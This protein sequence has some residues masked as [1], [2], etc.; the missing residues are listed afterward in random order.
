[1]KSDFKKIIQ[2]DEMLDDEIKL[3]KYIDD[4]ESSNDI[5]NYEDIE[6]RILNKI[7]NIKNENKQMKN[8][9]K[10]TKFDYLKVAGF[11]ILVLI[12]WNIGS[13]TGILSN[14]QVN[15]DTSKESENKQTKQSIDEIYQNINGVTNKI[16]EFFVTPTNL[17]RG[18]E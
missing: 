15:A 5:N 2:I 1:M 18:N 9:Q 12:L 10:M 11:T 6:D 16:S 14:S 17:E 13:M 8:K 7:K 4:I 3:Q